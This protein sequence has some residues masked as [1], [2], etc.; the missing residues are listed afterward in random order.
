MIAGSIPGFIVAVSAFQ[1]RTRASSFIK[2][3]TFGVR[4]GGHQQDRSGNIRHP[5]PQS[6]Q[7]FR[8]W[9]CATFVAAPKGDLIAENR[10][11]R[12]PAYRPERSSS[13]LDDNTVRKF[14]RLAGF[15]GDH[16]RKQGDASQEAD[17]IPEDRARLCAIRSQHGNC[18]DL[19]RRQE[20]R[21]IS[22][23]RQKDRNCRESARFSATSPDTSSPASPTIRSI[24]STSCCPGIGRRAQPRPRPPDQPARSSDH[25]YLRSAASATATTMPWPRRSMASTRPRS[26]GGSVRGQVLRRWKWRH[27]AGSIGSTITASSAPSGI[28]PPAEPEANYYAAIENLDMAA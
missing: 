2:F 5:R 21:V 13:D 4:A 23:C 19:T 22:E 10:R 12:I 26:S 6:P 16:R 24:A 7:N 9:V 14:D 18:R 28:F 1:T 8:V 15:F 11:E 25:A 20:L 27:C 3:A 17:N